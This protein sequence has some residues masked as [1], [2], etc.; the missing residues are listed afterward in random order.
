M[1][2]GLTTI[3]DRVHLLDEVATAVFANFMNNMYYKYRLRVAVGEKIRQIEDYG[4]FCSCKFVLLC[5]DLGLNTVFSV[6]K[7]D[8]EVQEIVY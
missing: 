7:I 2:H 3:R 8:I 6:G 5:I 4:P 1:P